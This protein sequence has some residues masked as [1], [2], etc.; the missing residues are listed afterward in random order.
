MPRPYNPLANAAASPLRLAPAT[1]WQVPVGAG[2]G[3]PTLG[4]RNEAKLSKNTG[5]V[6]G[7]KGPKARMTKRT[8]FGRNCR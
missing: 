7:A 6:R 5:Q 8:Q 2:H 1:I 3:R 4:L